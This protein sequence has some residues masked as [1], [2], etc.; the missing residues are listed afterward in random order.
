MVVGCEM[1]ACIAGKVRKEE[2]AGGLEQQFR[3]IGI[4]ISSKLELGRILKVMYM[5]SIKIPSMF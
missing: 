2:D 5:Y 1:G 4:Q 3:L